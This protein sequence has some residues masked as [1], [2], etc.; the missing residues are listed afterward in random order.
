MYICICIKHASK[1]VLFSNQKTKVMQKL[2][3]VIIL[4]Y[5]MTSFGQVAVSTNPLPLIDPSSVLDISSSNKG[6]LHPRMNK[7]DRD[8]IT[9]PAH[10]LMIYQMDDNPGY[11]YNAGT[12]IVPIWQKVQTNTSILS[13]IG[14]TAISSLPF[15]ITQAGSYYL[16]QSLSGASGI[17]VSASNVYIDLNGHTLSGLAGNTSAGIATSGTFNNLT[18]RNG[19]V[20]N[21]GKEGINFSNSHSCLFEDL[22]LNN[23]LRDGLFSG[24]NAIVKKIIATGNSQDGID[25]GESSMVEQCICE[26]NLNDG[27][28][29]DNG[30]ICSSCSAKSNS[31][32]GIKS[33]GMAS[34]QNCNA[35]SNTS[36]GFQLGIGSEANGNNAMNNLSYGYFVLEGCHLFENIARSNNIGFEL[37]GNHIIVENCSAKNNTSTGFSCSFNYV[38]LLG[39]TSSNN[40]H[41]YNISG[42]SNLLIK[43]TA[44]NNTTS[45]FTVVPSNNVGTILSPATLN[46]N[47]NPN[48]NISY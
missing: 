16:N 43:N 12:T 40:V 32:V 9:L 3:Y 31:L 27:I 20:S 10:S 29:L 39:N 11:Y 47:T 33:T 34:I 30:S 42:T 25:V 37:Y 8:N 36:H 4:F 45:G 15:T 22:L 5:S 44:I 26:M 6:V 24:K 38:H 23:N 7:I 1:G 14:R 2:L 48:A 41:G 21:W 17:T 46:T 13:L 35:L 28:E 18:V 19:S